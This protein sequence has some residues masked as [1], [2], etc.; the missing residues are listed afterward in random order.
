VD[1]ARDDHRGRGS[2]KRGLAISVRFFL[3]LAIFVPA[4]GAVALVGWQGLQA[5]QHTATALYQDHL[6][7]ADSTAEL[8]SQ[9]DAT[10]LIVLELL[11]AAPQARLQL[12]ATLVGQTIP[13]VDV[14][15]AAV[16]Q[17]HA[18][19]P[20]ERR[21]TDMIAAD[22]ARFH[23]LVAQGALAVASP[24]EATTAGIEI[25]TIFDDASAQAN[26]LV[27]REQVQAAQAQ[28]AGRSSYQR[29]LDLML[30]IVAI[31]LV[32]AVGMV[33]WLIR[34]V[35]PRTLSYARFA[36]RIAAGDDS[37]MLDVRGNDEIGDLGRTLQEMA[38][39]RSAERSYERTQTDF[40]DTLQVTADERE[41]YGLLKHHLE[42]SLPGTE[43]TL[44]NRNNSADRLQA[45]TELAPDSTL[46]DRL[47]GAQPRS[48][49]AVRMAR[50][51]HRANDVSPL[52]ACDVCG[53]CPRETTC[54]PL[55]VRGEVIGSV[56]AEHPLPLT[57]DEHR[58]IR[59]SVNQA[60]P[61]LGNLRNL[62]IVELR[63][64]TDALTGLP[65]RRAIQATLQRMI[66]Q[67]SRTLSP[68][69]A[70]MLD[71][72]HFK[73][74]ND[75][76]GHDRGDEV[77]AGV[78]AALQS[79]LRASDF[80]GRWGGEEFIILLPDTGMQEAVKLAERVRASVAE[81]DVPA[82]GTRVTI[83]IGIATVPD[84]A[85]DAEHLQRSADRAL[86]TA[87]RKGRDRVETATSDH[88]SA[89]PDRAGEPDAASSPTA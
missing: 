31:A 58:R 45:V 66:A 65:N 59:E 39:R 27:Q 19:D 42:R 53:A 54:T 48:C 32:A 5:G 51:Q 46:P 44:L 88:S 86:Y 17:L 1:T 36:G 10:H 30:M 74:I 4:L 62:A 38:E 18:D 82:V 52:L 55:I 77:L 87:K 43:V 60:A 72:D 70:L 80:A 23:T 73:N 29:H 2:T 78:G 85:S 89:G 79:T 21:A 71:L 84:H 28:A 56:L 75:Q 81:I 49:L 26:A 8:N 37:A 13:Q 20:Q 14:T 47:E 9:L 83:S 15:L 35:L 64:A 40:T 61:V 22:W 7:T 76:Y 69:S 3:V 63:A 33:L 67:A 16:R 12:M 34:S 57:T 68:M 25:S 24:A 6:L 41:A 50:P 11:L